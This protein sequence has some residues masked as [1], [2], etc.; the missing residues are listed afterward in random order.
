MTPT[1][2]ASE[3]KASA[4][5]A[6]A[7][8]TA[9]AMADHDLVELLVDGLGDRLPIVACSVV[10]LVSGLLESLSDED[11]GVAE[12]WLE[13]IGRGVEAMPEGDL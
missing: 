12:H 6:V 7:L 1:F 3:R 11:P 8:L 13:A 9:S 5:D 2:T 10:G 4:R